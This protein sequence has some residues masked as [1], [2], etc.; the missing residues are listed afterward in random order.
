MHEFKGEVLYISRP[1][2]AIA[3]RNEQGK[4][5]ICESSELPADVDWINKY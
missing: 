3:G 1:Y 4:Q 5:G 2:Y